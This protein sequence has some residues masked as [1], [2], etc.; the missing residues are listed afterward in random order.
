MNDETKKEISESLSE[1]KENL[2]EGNMIAQNIGSEHNRDVAIYHVENIP[3]KPREE[4]VL[5]TVH[6]PLSLYTFYKIEHKEKDET[7]TLK[8]IED[9]IYQYNDLPAIEEKMF[10]SE[11]E[12][13]QDE[14]WKI[15]AEESASFKDQPIKITI[16]GKKLSKFTDLLLDSSDLIIIHE[17]VVTNATK[18]LLSFA[19]EEMKEYVN[20]VGNTHPYNKTNNEYNVE[21]VMDIL[22]ATIVKDLN[23]ETKLELGLDKF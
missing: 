12:I 6:R 5:K 19:N 21:K 18:T 15:Q 7:H 17:N 2:Q 13:E 3:E 4:L 16:S 22:V 11:K 14:R 10:N 8:Y 20:K 23:R 1:L 9:A